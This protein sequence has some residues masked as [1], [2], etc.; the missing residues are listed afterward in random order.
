MLRVLNAVGEI[1][2]QIQETVSGIRL[3]KAAGAEGWEEE[4]FRALTQRHYT[5]LKRNE[6]W[7]QFFPPATEMVT[8][9]AI[10]GLLWY[11]AYL[12]LGKD[13]WRHPR[14]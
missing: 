6:R 2:S 13:R 3:V 1:S 12:V 8:A 9:M 4:R 11:G 5:A 14:F 10:L 7:R